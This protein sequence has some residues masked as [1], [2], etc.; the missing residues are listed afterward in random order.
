MRERFQGRVPEYGAY[1]IYTGL[2]APPA[3]GRYDLVLDMRALRSSG[4]R[5]LAAAASAVTSLR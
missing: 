4:R 2:I 3:P 1:A 5:V